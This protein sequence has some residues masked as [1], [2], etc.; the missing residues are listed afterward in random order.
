MIV[1]RW[2]WL[3]SIVSGSSLINIDYFL[4]VIE[5]CGFGSFNAVGWASC[6]YSQ[7]CQHLVNGFSN[8]FAVYSD[9]VSRTQTLLKYFWLLLKLYWRLFWSRI[10]TGVKTC[11]IIMSSFWHVV[12]GSNAFLSLS[13]RNKLLKYRTNITSVKIQKRNH[14]VEWREMPRM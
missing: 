9:R 11:S 2:S 3:K 7:R 1:W 10:T 4:L 8:C 13:S 5:P 12:L 6:I 14:N